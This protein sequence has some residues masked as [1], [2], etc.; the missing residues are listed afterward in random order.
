V[1]RFHF[2][3]KT[4]IVPLVALCSLRVSEIDE[5]YGN[6]ALLQG[7]MKGGTTKFGPP[8]YYEQVRCMTQR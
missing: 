5:F 3:D 7:K 1:L 4:G 8:C 2:K 6:I